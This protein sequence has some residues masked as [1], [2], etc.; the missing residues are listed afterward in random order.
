MKHNRVNDV[1]QDREEEK[2][3]E[4]IHEEPTVLREKHEG[5]NG[6]EGRAEVCLVEIKYK[7]N[8]G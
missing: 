3:K 2:S 1:R 5:K 4:W 7:H 6:K 8:P